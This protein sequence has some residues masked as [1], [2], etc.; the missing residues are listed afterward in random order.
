MARD[1]NPGNR[2]LLS[3]ESLHQLPD[4]S[5]DRVDTLFATD[6]SSEVE[7]GFA[8]DVST[9]NKINTTDPWETEGEGNTPHSSEAND[10]RPK[11][12]EQVV[13]LKDVATLRSMYRAEKLLRHSQKWPPNNSFN[14]MVSFCRHDIT[15]LKV[16]AIV[17]SANK[18]MQVTEENALSSTTLNN[19]IHKAAG[20]G[21]AKEIVSKGDLLVGKPVLTRG[22]NLP[23]R[24][25][26]HVASPGYYSGQHDSLTECYRS[27]LD[28]AVKNEIKTLAFPC[29]GTGGIGL[30]PER[31]AQI[32]LQEVRKYLDEQTEYQFE[33]II[34]CAH[35]AA[36][37]KA[38]VDN[39]SVYF[40]CSQIDLDISSLAVKVSEV[41][42]Q[43]SDACRQVNHFF[44]RLD[45]IS[46]FENPTAF[47]D[48]TIGL[49][50][51]LYQIQSKLDSIWELLQSSME[52]GT[53]LADIELACVVLASLCSSVTEAIELMKITSKYISQ[54][55]GEVWKDYIDDLKRMSRIDPLELLSTC[56][57]FLG[58][59]SNS[60]AKN[61]TE[62]EEMPDMRRTLET[63]AMRSSKKGIEE[64]Q[65]RL[66]LFTEALYVRQ[67]RQEATDSP[68]IGNTVTSDQIP[69]LT[70]LYK[71]GELQ[72]KHTTAL[73]SPNFN[74]LVCL[75]RE[76]ITKLQ[77]DVLV[78]STNP[79]FTGS[80]M[81]NRSVFAK[82]GPE[83]QKAVAAFGACRTGDVWGTGGYN[84]P[85]KYILH[86]VPPPHFTNNARA[87]IAQIYQQI[88][89]KAA[90]LEARSVA[91]P[92]L[93]NGG[94]YGFSAYY[95]HGSRH[96]SA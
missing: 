45:P 59:L 50:S 53:M 35:T 70:H 90:K 54:S 30:H 8:V 89:Q 74:D 39:I 62:P 32:A 46:A 55:V 63:Y 6:L 20:P 27:A 94:F 40:P 29:L 7:S 4:A 19:T 34:F 81:L 18:T 66:D 79:S 12:Q 36:D 61:D 73:P 5:Q 76:D 25:I 65:S 14:Q 44:V 83:L 52:F 92:C 69:T 9:G 33:R 26:I 95:L 11:A 93:G 48:P 28:L 60:I 15:K 13:E 64:D 24:Y 47:T 87:V 17:N 16:D 56:E 86:V 72:Q 67:F 96:W 31:A 68:H 38:Y 22:H 43:I 85:A 41:C 82:G 21:L 88:L 3:A 42:K 10:A 78:N 51:Q 57:A 75:I 77:V 37:E 49:R 91:I 80:G 84:L 71:L 2:A 1:D 23:S 58:W